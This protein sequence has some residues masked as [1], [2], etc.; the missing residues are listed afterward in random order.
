MKLCEHD[1]RFEAPPEIAENTLLS[2][3]DDPRDPDVA[4]I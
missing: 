3:A 1:I 2:V 4:L